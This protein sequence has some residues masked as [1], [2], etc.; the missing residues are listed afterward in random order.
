MSHSKSWQT[1][2]GQSMLTYTTHCFSRGKVM[3]ARSLIG[4][5]TNS[6]MAS[7]NLHAMVCDPRIMSIE[8][9]FLLDLGVANV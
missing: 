4:Y 8:N 3:G 9:R 5:T 2:K 1:L 6:R 7:L